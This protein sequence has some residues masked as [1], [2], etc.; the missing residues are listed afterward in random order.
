MKTR[1]HKELRSAA[2]ELKAC[3][4][5]FH[6]H[7]TAFAWCLHHDVLSEEIWAEGPAYRIDAIKI[8]KPK[9]EHA[10]RYRNFRPVKSTKSYNMNMWDEKKLREQF[11]QEWPDNTWNGHDIFLRKRKD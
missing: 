6:K 5:A 11:N 8:A 10:V 2:A 9:R 1:K 7:R 4:M 3:K